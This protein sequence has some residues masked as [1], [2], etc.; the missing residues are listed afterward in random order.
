MMKGRARLVL[1][2]VVGIG[3]VWT[4]AWAGFS[5][6]SR[7]KMT[8]EKIAAYVESVE[9]SRLSPEA[10]A[11]ALR[12]LADRLNALS[13]EERRRARLEGLWRPWFDQMTEA[14]KLD[15]LEATLPAGFKQMLTA[16]EQ[17]QEEQRRKAIDDAMRRLREART[18]M[19]AGRGRPPTE[20]EPVLSEE[21]QQQ[22]A[23]IGLRSVYTESSAQTKA[24]LAPVLEEVQR[25]ME[26]GRAF[27][28]RR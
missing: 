24:E 27:R 28:G 17:M 10:R 15:F 23:L 12:E 19:A 16:F 8:V 9:L 21:L 18:E 1:I 14:E 25:M 20:E 22:A 5:L 11:R 7:S 4:L 3:L 2:A 6:S 26:T 13:Y